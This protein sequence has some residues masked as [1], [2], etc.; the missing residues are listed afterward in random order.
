MF[1][2]IETWNVEIIF[3]TKKRLLFL[4]TSIILSQ[5]SLAY[6]WP[7]HTTVSQVKLQMELF[8]LA[9]TSLRRKKKKICTLNINIFKGSL[10]PSLWVVW[11]F[12]NPITWCAQKNAMKHMSILMS[13][14]ILNTLAWFFYLRTK[15][16]QD[17]FS[18]LLFIHNHIFIVQSR[19]LLMLLLTLKTTDLMFRIPATFN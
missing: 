12:K 10:T 13:I 5:S 2:F 15:K 18:Y 17:S 16:A 9:E 19:L 8:L 4:P 6:T 14:N 7:K 1:Q 3:L 11:Q